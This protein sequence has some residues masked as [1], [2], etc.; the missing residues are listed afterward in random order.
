MNSFT[1]PSI[2]LPPQLFN[3]YLLSVH[4]YMRHYFQLYNIQCVYSDE[5]FDTI[6]GLLEPRS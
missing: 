2:S 3:K 6:L 1:H 5:A 4:Q